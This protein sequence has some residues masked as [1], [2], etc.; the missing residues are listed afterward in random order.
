[1]TNELAKAAFRNSRTRYYCAT[2][3]ATIAGAAQGMEAL[4]VSRRMPSMLGGCSSGSA[5]DMTT[6]LE[7]VTA[8]F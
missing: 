3:V 6:Q 4:M 2:D 8:L 1:M 7:S 5:D